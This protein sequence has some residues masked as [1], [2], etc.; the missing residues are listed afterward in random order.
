M[1]FYLTML[2]LTRFLREDSPMVN[3]NNTDVAGRVAYDQW[4]Q[5]DFLCH[6]YILG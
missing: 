4:G 3:E 1:L 5:A 2:H 6:N